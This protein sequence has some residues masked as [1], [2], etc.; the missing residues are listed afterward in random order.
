MCAFS[1]FLNAQ[2]HL[3]YYNKLDWHFLEK[4]TISPINKFKFN[5]LDVMNITAAKHFQ[6]AWHNYRPELFD[7]KNVK[8]NVSSV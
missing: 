2:A 6:Q 5:T 8:E 7:H 4:L 1:Y 3:I